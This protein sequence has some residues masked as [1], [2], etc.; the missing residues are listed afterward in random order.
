MSE[1]KPTC[2]CKD[3]GTELQELVRL[4]KELCKLQSV[5]NQK[6]DAAITGKADFAVL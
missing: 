6:V 1:E 5:L 2:N 4:V 3:Y